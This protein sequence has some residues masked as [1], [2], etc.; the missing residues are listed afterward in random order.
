MRLAVHNTHRQTH[1]WQQPWW[2]QDQSHIILESKQHR[3]SSQHPEMRLPP[4]PCFYK[5]VN[6][7]FIPLCLLPPTNCIKPQICPLESRL[8]CWV[9]WWDERPG[10]RRRDVSAWSTELLSAS[11]RA[12]S[13]KDTLRRV[14]SKYHTG[15]RICR[16]SRYACHTIS[17]A[18]LCCRTKLMLTNHCTHEHSLWAKK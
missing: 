10:E 9:D 15:A 3:I 14:N 16:V 1:R 5:E 2:C 17:G 11:L 12:S 6:I 4:Q 8:N 18:P 13:V 7:S